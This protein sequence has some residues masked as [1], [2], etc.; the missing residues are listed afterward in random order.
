MTCRNRRVV[1]DLFSQVAVTTVRTDKLERLAEQW[2]ERLT[3]A[4]LR[5]RVVAH[6]EGAHEQHAVKS[7]SVGTRTSYPLSGN[8]QQ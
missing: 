4:A 6:G 8:I 1:T 7:A 3:R 5:G 2:V